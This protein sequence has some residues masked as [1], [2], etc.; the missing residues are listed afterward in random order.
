MPRQGNTAFVMPQIMRD[1]A[2]FEPEPTRGE[3]LF[4]SLELFDGELWMNGYQVVPYELP[5]QPDGPLD[6]VKD[7]AAEAMLGGR[8]LAPSPLAVALYQN[9]EYIPVWF[10][11]KRVCFLDRARSLNGKFLCG[12][13]TL[14]SVG[15]MF[16][17]ISLD[18]RWDPETCVAAVLAEPERHVVP[19]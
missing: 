1:L 6:L 19:Q 12:T 16:S 7:I 3:P 17:D 5:A 18:A 10:Y 11:G 15:L 14:A 4:V 2:Q 13:V 9:R 8:R